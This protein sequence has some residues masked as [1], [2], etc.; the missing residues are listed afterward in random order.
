MLMRDEGSELG[1]RLD[2][3]KAWAES[4][5]QVSQDT[6]TQGVSFSILV[7]NCEHTHDSVALFAEMA[8]DFLSKEALTNECQL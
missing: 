3:W 7:W 5:I 6:L 1:P 4:L 8:V 2:S